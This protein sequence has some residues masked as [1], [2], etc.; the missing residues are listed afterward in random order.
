MADSS[1]LWYR[2]GYALETARGTPRAAAEAVQHGRRAARQR[3]GEASSGGRDAL[4]KMGSGLP[5]KPGGKEGDGS[6]AT[7]GNAVEGLRELPGVELLLSVGTGTVVTRLLGLWTPRHRPA[8]SR[9]LRAAAAGAGASV[10]RE[11]LHP[12]L[13][14]EPRLPEWEEG[15]GERMAAGAARGLLYGSVAEPRLPGSAL[16]RGAAYGT[17]EYLLSPYGGLKGLVGKHAPHRR[18][19]ILATVVEEL[20]PGEETFLDHLAYGV[21]LG[22]LYGDDASS[23]MASEEE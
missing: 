5:G 22:L 16:L 1:N 3:L 12:L 8:L 20:E 9:L 13:R 17:A 15:I 23:G 18:I 2:I 6:E 14:G 10:L 4:R 21:A 7:P 11:L 19:P